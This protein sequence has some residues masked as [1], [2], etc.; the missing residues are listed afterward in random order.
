MESARPKNRKHDELELRCLVVRDFRWCELASLRV[1][2]YDRPFS[3]EIYTAEDLTVQRHK[4]Q[5]CR[6]PLAYLQC[7][8][9][10]PQSRPRT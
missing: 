9:D 7:E 3:S 2:V 4:G 10:S 1:H 5:Q 6:N 8:T